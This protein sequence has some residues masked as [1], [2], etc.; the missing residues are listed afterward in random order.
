MIPALVALAIVASSP[1][2]QAFFESKVRPVLAGS[3]VRCHGPRKASGGLRLDSREHLA[4]GGSSGPALDSDAPGE[5]LLHEAV[6]RSGDATPMPP[7]KPLAP[8]AVADLRRWVNAGAPWPDSAAPI[9]GG[10]HWAF[11]PIRDVAPPTVPGAAHPIDA[12]LAADQRRKGLVPVAPADNR[13]LIRRATFDLT[14]LPPTP[15]EVEAFLADLIGD[16]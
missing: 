3:C 10:R 15:E 13:T 11:E 7:D 5:S 6:G 8:E 16:D 9:S 1:A 2:D 4:R 14:G 12:F